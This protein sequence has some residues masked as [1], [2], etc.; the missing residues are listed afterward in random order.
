MSCTP[1]PAIQSCDI[2]QQLP[3]FDIGY[4]ISKFNM[5]CGLQGS[6]CD[7]SHALAERGGCTSG[8]FCQHANFLDA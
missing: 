7:I 2:G 5:D 1:E 3:F 8:R 4:P 6:K